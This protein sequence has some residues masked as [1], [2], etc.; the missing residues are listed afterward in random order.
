LIARRN[1]T[2]LLGNG[3]HIKRIRVIAPTG[4]GEDL[5][6]AAE[7]EDFYLIKYENGN[8]SQAFRPDSPAATF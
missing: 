2:R 6:W 7:I 8:I 3:V 1:G 5:E 4:N